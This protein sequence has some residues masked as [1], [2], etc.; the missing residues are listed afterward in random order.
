MSRYIQ[1]QSGSQA[2]IYVTP[3]TLA[4]MQARAAATLGPSARVNVIGPV[5]PAENA[6]ITRETKATEAYGAS[7]RREEPQM[8]YIQPVPIQEPIKQPEPQPVPV[9]LP[10]PTATEPAQ[11]FDVTAP[12]QD[13]TA[14]GLDKMMPLLLIGGLMFL[15]GRL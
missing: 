1:L 8:A 12:R 9:V 11:V 13:G 7:V 5:S 10:T 15:G 4:K 6:R 14:P 2:K 3:R